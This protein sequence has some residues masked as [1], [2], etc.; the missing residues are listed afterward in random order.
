MKKIIFFISLFSTLLSFGQC[1]EYYI[2]E[3]ISGPSEKFFATGSPIRFCHKLKG[4][5]LSGYTYD[6]YQWSGISPQYITITK[7]GGVAG[8]LILD[9]NDKTLT[10]SLNGSPGSQLYSISLDKN[11]HNKWLNDKPK[12]DK[13][14]SDKLKKE[15]EQK[16]QQE[17]KAQK[18]NT[19]TEKYNLDNY[20][21]EVDTS[22]VNRILRN[23]NSILHKLLAFCDKDTLIIKFDQN[24]NVIDDDRSILL[25]KYIDDYCM[26]LQQE[27]SNIG[28]RNPIEKD[29]FESLFYQDC[30]RQVKY[31]FWDQL[32]NKIQQELF[33][34]NRRMTGSDMDTIIEDIKIRLKSK[35]TFI[36]KRRAD[37]KIEYVVVPH[38]FSGMK[39]YFSESTRPCDNLN[40]LFTT[41]I[42][43]GFK[44]Y[45][46]N[47]NEVIW[48]QDNSDWSNKDLLVG[49]LSRNNVYVNN[50]Y[51]G[52]K[53]QSEWRTAYKY[54]KIKSKN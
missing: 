40:G 1:N 13:E 28:R 43:D 26:N 39:L 23:E 9:L 19:I 47:E 41:N 10:V 32:D 50:I 45:F 29:R 18:I 5:A 46:N 44:A 14:I 34:L 54:K 37:C 51:V 30:R 11:D 22:I 17:L 6:A 35:I 49:G 53:I 4:V 8:S 27:I 2:N 15:Q 25:N 24:G 52:D 38:K 21:K 20:F 7:D 36:Y 33:P 3:L 48:Y 16:I 42:A 31:P 12:R